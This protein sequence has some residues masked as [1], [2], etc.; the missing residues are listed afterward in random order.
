MLVTVNRPPNSITALV[1]LSDLH[2]R[3]YLESNRALSRLVFGGTSPLFE[4]EDIGARLGPRNSRRKP[5]RSRGRTARSLAA[6]IS[7]RLSTLHSGYPLLVH[8]IPTL[9]D[10][11]TVGCTAGLPVWRSSAGRTTSAIP[12][13]IAS[14]LPDPA[15]RTVF[16]LFFHGCGRWFRT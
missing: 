5:C 16:E 6:R 4:V 7:L 14:L 13:S 2:P 15:S 11:P 9:R 12:R 1:E 3:I 8:S 10:A